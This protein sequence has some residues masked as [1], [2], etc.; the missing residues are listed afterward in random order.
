MA[1]K[2]K[3]VT[4]QETGV[5]EIDKPKSAKGFKWSKNP[6]HELIPVVEESKH[7]DNT[8]S[9][10]NGPIVDKAPSEELSS[11]E[12]CLTT[13]VVTAPVIFHHPSVIIADKFAPL[14]KG[15]GGNIGS[16]ES[17]INDNV[18]IED[19]GLL[20][21]N[22]GHFDRMFIPN[23]DQREMTSTEHRKRLKAIESKIDDLRAELSQSIDRM[24]R[25]NHELH[26]NRI[27]HVPPFMTR[28]RNLFGL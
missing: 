16:P 9:V 17:F 3:I 20:S 13:K 19:P 21:I 15:L 8:A 22:P 26:L 7:I 25:E 5:I 14:P 24:I 2:K 6:D 4:E 1:R 11:V 12:T 23:P 18:P 10:S 27:N 28:L